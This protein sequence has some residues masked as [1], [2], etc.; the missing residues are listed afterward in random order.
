VYVRIT[1]IQ[2]SIGA[3]EISLEEWLTD[4]VGKKVAEEESKPAAVHGGVKM[5]GM[6]P[7]GFKLPGM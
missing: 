2:D 3:Q 5:P 6:P 7:G 4:D 1:I